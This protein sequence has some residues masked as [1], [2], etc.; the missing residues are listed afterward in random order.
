MALYRA[1]RVTSA[2]GV[3]DRAWSRFVDRDGG[4]SGG[5][6]QKGVE[7]LDAS[8]IDSIRFRI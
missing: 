1:F 8:S 3:S 5:G 7:A 4:C 6:R 2:G